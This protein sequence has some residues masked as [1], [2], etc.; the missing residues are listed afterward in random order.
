VLVNVHVW[1]WV[2]V[3]GIVPV[4]VYGWL[5]VAYHWR[6]AMWSSAA[7]VGYLISG[8]VWGPIVVL[9]IGRVRW[10]RLYTTV[11]TNLFL[12]YCYALLW[13]FLFERFVEPP[14]EIEPIPYRWPDWV[15]RGLLGDEFDPEQ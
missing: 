3:L 7:G 1:L 14:G 4:G 11:M 8:L 2:G 12:V 15:G 9:N 6:P 13:V 10:G 5:L